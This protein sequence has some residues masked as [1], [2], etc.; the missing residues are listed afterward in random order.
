MRTIWV[1]EFR[2]SSP[3]L[4][5]IE[6]EKETEKTFSVGTKTEVMGY[7]P[8]YRRV[9]KHIDHWFDT[10]IAALEWLIG[11][12]EKAIRTL[13]ESVTASQEQKKQLQELLVMVKQGMPVATEPQEGETTP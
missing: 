2:Y 3:N 10:P 12:Q 13:E 11:Q 8:V 9:N 5:K 6:V 4:V 7:V 1:A